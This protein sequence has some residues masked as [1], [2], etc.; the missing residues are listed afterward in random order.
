MP[1]FYIARRVRH[2][3]SQMFDLVADIERYPK[4]VPLCL[5]ANILRK[6]TDKAGVDHLLVDMEVGHRAIRQQ[7][8]TRDTLDRTRMKIRIEHVDG[9]FR[10][11]ENVWTFHD[12]D[13]GGCRVDFTAEYEFR[14]P[15]LGA[16]MGSMF[17]IALRKISA[18]FEARADAIY[19]RASPKIAL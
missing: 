15:I 11:F 19:G 16:L 14:S 10:V 1:S 7:F 4:F 13:G 6:T 12:E 18:A 17:E 9:P 8:T 2:R 3:A 5:G